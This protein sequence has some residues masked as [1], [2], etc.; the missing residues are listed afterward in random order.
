VRTAATFEVRRSAGFSAFHSSIRVVSFP[1]WDLF[2]EQ[3]AAYKESVLP[4][5]VLTRLAVE[6]GATFGW[7]R[8]VGLSGK[9]IGIDHF[10]A[11][12]PYKV[13]FEHFGFT[14]DNVFAQAKALLKSR[15]KTKPQPRKV[16]KVA[17]SVNR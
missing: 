4:K 5:S 2:E 6:A 17:A 3:D 15:K 9:T 7:E 1:S 14:V 13:I 12:A 8:Y 16:A 10:G 11:S